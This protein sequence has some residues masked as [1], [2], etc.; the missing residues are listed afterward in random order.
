MT[1][2]SFALRG[3]WHARELTNGLRCGLLV[4]RRFAAAGHGLPRS[5]HP[6]TLD[7]DSAGFDRRICRRSHGLAYPETIARVVTAKNPRRRAEC[8]ERESLG[9]TIG[10]LQQSA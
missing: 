7:G 3:L 9:L 4:S 5:P 6:V 2:V 10:R 8:G 1:E